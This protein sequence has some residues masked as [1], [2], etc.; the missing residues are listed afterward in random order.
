MRPSRVE[1]EDAMADFRTAH[2]ALEAILAD[3][4]RA[5]AKTALEKV[6][7]LLDEALTTLDK[8]HPHTL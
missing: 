1:V 5:D 7:D 8:E 6:Y 2:Q 4:T 3:E